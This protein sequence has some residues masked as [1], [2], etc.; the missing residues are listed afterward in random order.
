ME[1]LRCFDV[2]NVIEMAMLEK[3]RS[4]CGPIFLP[5]IHICGM[6]VT[7]IRWDLHLVEKIPSLPESQ[8]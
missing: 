8:F 1:K 3:G 4:C 2:M 7:M 6:L 5:F